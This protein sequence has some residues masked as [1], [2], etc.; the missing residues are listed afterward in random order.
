[1]DWKNLTFEVD[2]AGIG[3]ATLDMPG[4]PFNVFSDDMIDEIEALIEHIEQNTATV[5]G[6]VFASGKD[7]FMAGADLAMVRGFRASGTSRIRSTC[8][9]PLA[10]SAPVTFM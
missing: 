5:K 2:T 10:S 9:R 4:R 1:M 8:S 7:A 6:V 3:L